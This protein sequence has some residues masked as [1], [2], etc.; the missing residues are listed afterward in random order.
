MQKP[1]SGKFQVT[2]IYYFNTSYCSCMFHAKAGLSMN[3]NDLTPETT[4]YLRARKSHAKAKVTPFDIL[5][6]ILA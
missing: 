6:L 1:K 4:D 3:F 5:Y 2:V